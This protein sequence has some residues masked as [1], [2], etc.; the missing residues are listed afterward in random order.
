MLVAHHPERAVVQPLLRHPPRR[1]GCLEDEVKVRP[2]ACVGHVDEPVGAEFEDS[3]PNGGHVGRVVAVAAVRLGDDQRVLV[4]RPRWEDHLGAPPLRVLIGGLG[5]P[6]LLEV[7]D[8]A[9]D[10]LVV[11]GLAHLLQIHLQPRVDLLELAARHVADLLPRVARVAVAGLQLHHLLVRRL[12]ERLVLVE[13]QLRVLVE[14][15]Q[16]GDRRRL[17]RVV[18]EDVL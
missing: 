9:G 7:R 4:L 18:G 12:L 6:D 14:L 3:I 13:E 15:L 16:V 10:V 2:L 11:E 17:A 1:P 8:D 5:Q